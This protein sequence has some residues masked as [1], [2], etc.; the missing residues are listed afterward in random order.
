MSVHETAEKVVDYILATQPPGSQMMQWGY[1]LAAALA[2]ARA[3][4]STYEDWSRWFHQTGKDLAME[5]AKAATIAVDDDRK[6]IRDEWKDRAQQAESSLAW[7]RAQYAEL[8]RQLAE[9]KSHPFDGG[10][11]TVMLNRA[12]V[13]AWHDDI[14]ASSTTTAERVRWLV[15]DWT[16]ERRWRAQVLSDIEDA[17]RETACPVGVRFADWIRRLGAQ[18]KA[19]GGKA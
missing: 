12:G 1:K 5:R 14:T 9:A 6:E 10:D 13:K 4:A 18:V 17:C 11:I 3:S 8:S 16:N 15:D 7:Y 19:L 2:S